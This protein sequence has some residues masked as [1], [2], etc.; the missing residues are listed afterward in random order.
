MSESNKLTELQ[1]DEEYEKLVKVFVLRA[2]AQEA[3]YRQIEAERE[4]ECIAPPGYLY[5]IRALSD[6]AL[7]KRINLSHDTWYKDLEAN[8]LVYT[9][10][11]TIQQDGFTTTTLTSWTNGPTGYVFRLDG[12]DPISINNNQFE[13]GLISLEEFSKRRLAGDKSLYRQD[14]PSD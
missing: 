14:T 10:A 3:H 12:T 9:P 11:I 6:G 13:I 7:T 2:L 5:K 8:S 1:I 4:A